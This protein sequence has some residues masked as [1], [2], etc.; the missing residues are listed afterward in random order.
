MKKMLIID[1]EAAICS[2]LRFALEDTYDVHTTTS[3]AE[4]VKRA[5]EMTFDLCLLDLKLGQVSGLDVLQTL[6][7][8]Q[9]QLVII[10]MTAYGTI[11]SAVEAV[12]LGA[13][14]Y[15]TKPLQMDELFTLLEQASDFLDLNRPIDALQQQLDETQGC[16]GLIGKSPLMRNV[17]Q[18]ITKVKDIDTTVLITG[19]SG[20]GKELVARAI[21]FAGRR[22]HHPFEVINCA[23]IPANL[24]ESELFGYERGAFTGAFSKKRGSFE[25]AQHGTIFLDEIGELPLTLQAKLLRAIQQRE[26]LPLGSD[27]TIQ[28]DVRVIAATNKDLKH[29]VEKGRFRE[30]LYF[31]LSVIEIE[32]PPLRERRQDLE[33]LC[34][35][36]I[37]RFNQSLG[38][39]IKGLSADAYQRLSQYDYP[40][41]VRE[42]ANIIE[43]A[44]VMCDGDY[45]RLQDLPAKVAQPSPLPLS[46]T[47]TDLSPLVGM[48]LKEME[49]Q[50]IMATLEANHGHRQRTA[51]MLG[52]SERGL[53]N[54]LKQYADAD[55]DER[56]DER[57]SR[58]ST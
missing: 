57:A 51:E 48:P 10:M 38:K 8:I 58:T 16:Y 37:H 5:K 45:I 21:H 13:Y 26:I 2:S 9:P 27:Q 49:K 30:D 7:T 55:A 33:L 56:A 20:T 39:S 40:G 14:S 25:R 42:L 24:L 18:M 23:A 29:A 41:N 19:E 3:A 53:R 28:L 50:L 44:M 31:R 22:N 35:H 54:K 17:Y 36:F 34:Q 11:S 15:L 52:I 47:R 1:D 43:S 6:K 12:K 4:G 46:I 32:L